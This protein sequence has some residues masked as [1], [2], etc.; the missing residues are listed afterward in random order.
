[1]KTVIVF[2]LFKLAADPFFVLCE[3]YREGEPERAAE[4]AK[5]AA[6]RGRFCGIV[7]DRRLFRGEL[8]NLDFRYSLR[9]EMRDPRA[10][11][12]WDSHAWD[13]PC[14]EPISDLNVPTSPSWHVKSVLL[15]FDSMRL[16]VFRP[17]HRQLT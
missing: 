14:S 3:L 6:G 16:I 11:R 10:G 7:N 15:A 2:R 4:V 12:V 17:R 9:A 13:E 5:I 1:M 8:D